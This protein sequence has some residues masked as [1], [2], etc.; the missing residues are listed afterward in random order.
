MN[1]Q[2]KARKW[3]NTLRKGNSERTQKKTRKACHKSGKEEREKRLNEARKL[4]HEERETV[5]N[6]NKVKGEHMKEIK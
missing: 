1:K 6:Q 4:K 2:G 5:K 3:K